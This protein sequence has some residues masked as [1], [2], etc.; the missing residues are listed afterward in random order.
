MCAGL[1]KP[2]IT[3]FASK[4]G[5]E[6]QHF[7]VSDFTKFSHTQS[8]FQHYSQVG[9]EKVVMTCGHGDKLGNSVCDFLLWFNSSDS[10]RVEAPGAHG[11]TLPDPSLILS[12]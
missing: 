9:L 10:F 4:D 3:I 5:F 11:N 8:P 6:T 12:L 1:E 2:I 7:T